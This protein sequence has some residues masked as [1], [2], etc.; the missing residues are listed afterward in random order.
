MGSWQWTTS[1]NLFKKDREQHLTAETQ[2]KIRL[3]TLHEASPVNLRK[4]CKTHRTMRIP[5]Q[6]N[7]LSF[8]NDVK[9]KLLLLCGAITGPL[10]TIAWIVEGANRANYD[11]L[12]HPIS[13]LAIGE[14]G[15]IQIVNFV[16]TGFL[17]FAFA[18]GLWRTFQ[19]QKV[20]TR[21]PLLIALIAI[22]FLG[23]G[24][25]VTDPMNGCPIGTPV[26]PLQYTITGRLHRL[27]SAFVFLGLPIAC[28]IFTRLFARQNQ[29]EWTIYSTVTG[30]AFVVMFIFTT[31][32]FAQVN[33]LANYAGLF[34]RITLTIGWLWL[35]FLSIYMLRIPAETPLTARK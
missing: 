1:S 17:T 9:T 4:R 20:N 34:Q 10:F 28:F 31:M 22:G 35:T 3:Y 12:R 21:V 32:G 8:G 7:A 30:I 14:L 16:V 2:R 25:F 27:F 33:G 13:S 6:S 26:L 24:I 23:A 15:W 11:W 18:F 19:S 29:R 5:M